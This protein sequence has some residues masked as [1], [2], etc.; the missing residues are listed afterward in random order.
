ME[1]IYS[2]DYT[3]C[4]LNTT[5]T[6]KVYFMDKCNFQINGGAY[7]SIWVTPSNNRSD[8]ISPE[9]RGIIQNADIDTLDLLSSW[10]TRLINSEIDHL[11]YSYIY[12]GYFICNESGCYYR[13]RYINFENISSTANFT[14][15]SNQ[16]IVVFNAS[17]ASISSNTNI[18]QI[19]LTNVEFFEAYNT[20]L[21][22]VF[23]SNSTALINI[24]KNE[25]VTIYASYSN[26][27]LLN[28]YP[29]KSFTINAINSS[30]RLYNITSIDNSNAK[31]IRL[32]NSS[33]NIT[34]IEIKKLML[35]L[36]Y[37]SGIIKNANLTSLSKFT[38]SHSQISC[39]NSSF[40]NRL[41]LVNST[42][43]LYN[44]S[45]DSFVILKVILMNGQFELKDGMI[46]N[47]DGEVISGIINK[48]LSYYTS[49]FQIEELYAY[50]SSISVTGYY[51]DYLIS[52]NTY[53]YLYN[54]THLSAYNLSS[55]TIIYV[56]IYNNSKICLNK[57]KVT[58]ISI[59]NGFAEL[60][61]SKSSLIYI[62]NGT[63]GLNYSEAGYIN[64]RDGS[65]YLYNSNI[66]GEIQS[67]NGLDT[68][69]LLQPETYP[70]TTLYVY[71]STVE[72]IMLFGNG[73]IDIINSTV[74]N[75]I[76][77]LHYV[78]LINSTVN[79]FIQRNYLVYSGDV[80][81]ENNAISGAHELLLNVINSDI[82][83][84]KDFVVGLESGNGPA[85]NISIINSS[86]L[87]VATYGGNLSITN[88]TICLIAVNG[89]KVHLEDV[90][91]NSSS[92]DYYGYIAG[93]IVDM[94]NISVSVNYFYLKGGNATLNSINLTGYCSTTIYNS[95]LSLSDVTIYYKNSKLKIINSNFLLLD[96]KIYYLELLRSNGTIDSTIINETA[97]TNS[98][99][100]MNDSYI[101][102][103]IRLDNGGNITAINTTIYKIILSSTTYPYYS[104]ARNI[105][106]RFINCNI[107]ESTVTFYL[108]RNS[109]KAYIC[110]ES[111]SGELYI[112]IL[113][114]NSTIPNQTYTYLMVTE[115]GAA[116]ISNYT[117][118]HVID[119]IWIGVQKDLSS[120][121]ITCY[122]FTQ[123]E[124]ELGVF[125]T[126][127]LCFEISDENP[128]RYSV[129]LN[130]TEILSGVYTQEYLLSID[131]AQYI[132]TSATYI[133]EIVAN[134]TFGNTKTKTITLIIYP[135]EP[136]LIVEKP[137]DS[138]II[139]KGE[140]IA[141]CW[142]AWDR[143]PYIYKI[144]QNNSIV[145]SNSWA[146]NKEVTLIFKA[147]EVGLHNITIVF[148]DKLMLS[149]KHTTL[150]YVKEM[151]I[152]TSQTTTSVETQTQV[153]PQRL[154]LTE[155]RYM[156]PM[157]L[158]AI[159]IVVVIAKKKTQKHK[160][161]E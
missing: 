142:T 29:N 51:S 122:N 86:I 138:Y 27:S 141:L 8:V 135:S 28:S 49:G 80:V 89:E 75:V 73:S 13:D 64:I 120:P 3:S 23:L 67:S 26:I 110:N 36:L 54:K 119:C 33:I 95:T 12:V 66:N 101:Y 17:Y 82:N 160:R 57:S 4:V 22:R 9:P 15:L 65:I 53:I 85:L 137:G 146:S 104:R 116:N 151:E 147:S 55:G 126:I 98:F 124:Y 130:G 1:G 153:Q 108:V 92:V 121:S 48:G 150:I 74:D 134:D 107:T 131:I 100:L 94:E 128:D 63:L 143:S 109:Q 61:K 132:N 14:E 76:Y 78:E 68:I 113:Y 123:L 91:I 157:L 52:I 7:Q 30:I 83:E 41:R 90:T 25:N 156:I 118:S 97:L 112:K 129:I 88:S 145:E 99:C 6:T 114:M 11:I 105:T 103:Y 44:V 81:I 69:R 140:Q 161:S 10:I 139:T 111:I 148:Y 152:T 47:Y 43:E 32:E 38:I 158:L 20:S 50:N 93:D 133:I 136:P 159:I 62:R 45:L 102:E 5:N 70:T 127:R 60:Y 24:T 115:Q 40:S 154:F 155:L 96:S 79:G 71:N 125:D 37:C 106:G 19:Y 46:T 59:N 39:Y 56:R 58:S 72:K 77:M 16:R 144:L 31:E 87:G 18:T 35:V 21:S 2:I 84:Y 117:G 42:L 149:S 34:G